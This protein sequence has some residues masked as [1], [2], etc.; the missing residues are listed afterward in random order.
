LT[1]LVL[2]ETIKPDSAL[3]LCISPIDSH[4]VSLTVD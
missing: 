4:A 2:V 1:T 3:G